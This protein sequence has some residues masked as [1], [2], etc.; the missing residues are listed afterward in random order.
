MKKLLIALLLLSINT[1]AYADLEDWT[2][3]EQKLYKS[4]VT[5]QAMDL[6]QAFAMIECQ[7][8]NP[9]CPFYER[10][11]IL[12][13]HPKKGEMVM[14]K[15]ATNFVLYNLLDKRIKKHDKRRTLIALNAISIIP[16]INNHQI[17]IGIYIPIL[18]YKQF[19]K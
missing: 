14:F 9:Q 2:Q 17:G 7:E 10:N 16:V 12:G 8:T 15:L 13:S 11:P 18:P 19:T 1:I 5:L 6:M 3:K 4:F